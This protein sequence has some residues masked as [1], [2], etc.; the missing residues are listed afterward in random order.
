MKCANCQRDALY[1]YQISGGYSIHYCQAH[2]PGF[3]T[4]QKKAG[5]LPLQ[6]PKPVETPAKSSKKK[7]VTPEPVAEET[8]AEE[9]PEED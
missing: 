6:V 9:T 7:E 1:T 8:S 2:L 3:L 5:L 4:S